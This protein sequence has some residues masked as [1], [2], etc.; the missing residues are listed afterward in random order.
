VATADDDGKGS[1][2]EAGGDDGRRCF[3][4]DHIVH[5]CGNVPRIP[6]SPPFQAPIRQPGEGL[7]EEDRAFH[8]TWPTAVGQHPHFVADTQEDNVPHLQGSPIMEIL[9]PVPEAQ[10]LGILLLEVGFRAVD[11]SRVQHPP[12]LTHCPS[13][14]E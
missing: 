7:A 3:E 14:Q 5:R 10:I 9:D 12:S 13:E 6:E 4:E 2:P 8:G 1:A 11:E